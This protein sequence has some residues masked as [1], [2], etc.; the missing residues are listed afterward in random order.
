MY[1]ER[2]TVKKSVHKHG[3]IERMVDRF[4]QDPRRFQLLFE[5]DADKSCQEK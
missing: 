2:F 5:N 3:F 4:G 1:Y